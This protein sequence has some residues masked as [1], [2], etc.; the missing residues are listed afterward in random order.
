MLLRVFENIGDTCRCYFDIKLLLCNFVKFQTLNIRPIPG[1]FTIEKFSISGHSKKN[2]TL[3]L[4]KGKILPGNEET[5]NDITIFS[6][7][8]IKIDENIFDNFTSLKS[9]GFFQT[10]FETSLNENILSE[11]L[12]KVLISL[13]LENAEMTLM[14]LSIFK[15]LVNLEN[16]SLKGNEQK[17][18]K[19]NEKFPQS[20]SN[21][22]N[23]TLNFCN[24]TDLND[25]TFE[26]LKS[27]ETLHM[28]KYD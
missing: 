25:D 12:G 1:N 28:P 2:E 20:L 18:G 3:T 24:L 5:I 11:K 26:H 7:K 19:F 13:E 15:N 22:K 9:L 6:R 23:L 10:T 27:L 8:I 21:L 16:L 17:N 4:E 14:N